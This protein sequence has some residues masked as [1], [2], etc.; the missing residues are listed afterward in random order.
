MKQASYEQE[1][2][3]LS[4]GL[5][6]KFDIMK[7]GLTAAYGR[8]YGPGL[9]VQQQTA[10]GLKYYIEPMPPGTGGWEILLKEQ[11][12][13]EKNEA[14]VNGISFFKEQTNLLPHNTEVVLLKDGNRVTCNYQ[15]KTDFLETMP[16]IRRASDEKLMQSIFASK[17]S[18]SFIQTSKERGKTRLMRRALLT[19]KRQCYSTVYLNFAQAT[20]NW[21]RKAFCQWFAFQVSGQVG[22][23]IQPDKWELP[24]KWEILPEEAEAMHKY[25]QELVFPKIQGVAIGLDNIDCLLEADRKLGTE[26]IQVIRYLHEEGT[27]ESPSIKFLLSHATENLDLE[28]GTELNTGTIIRDGKLDATEVAMLG[29]FYYKRPL[30][31]EET[32]VIMK[33]TKGGH[34]PLVHNYFKSSTIDL[35]HL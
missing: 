34:P 2:V 3:V 35:N 6:K 24:D 32:I 22:I 21:D 28:K 7:L 19:L 23:E 13:I 29:Q 12:A 17:R 25:L 30:S 15:A 20:K 18:L 16:Y 8:M 14:W 1:T 10:K 11:K 27:T 26:F 9:P 33:S 5:L 31:S 4:P